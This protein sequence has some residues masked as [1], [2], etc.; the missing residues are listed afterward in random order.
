VKILAAE[1]AARSKAF[2]EVVRSAC[3]Y[4]AAASD[5]G[6]T[7]WLRWENFVKDLRAR[8]KEA[9]RGT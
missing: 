2:E 9:P 5:D 1:E 3:E 8:A 7:A 6:Q 4:R